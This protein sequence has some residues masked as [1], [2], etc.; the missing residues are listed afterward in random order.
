MFIPVF[1]QE[2]RKHIFKNIQICSSQP[3]FRRPLYDG[4]SVIKLKRESLYSTTDCHMIKSKLHDRLEIWNLSSRVEK[5][6]T[7]SLRSLV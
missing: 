1:G 6:R 4:Y 3:L 7:R 5:Y 2:R